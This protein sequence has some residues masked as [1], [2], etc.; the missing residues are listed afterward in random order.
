MESK[1]PFDF[2]I[3]IDCGLDDQYFKNNQLLIDN[4]ENACKIK[5]QN[6][7]IRMHDG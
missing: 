6:A 5:K 2:P 1:G 3:L 4:F 7:T